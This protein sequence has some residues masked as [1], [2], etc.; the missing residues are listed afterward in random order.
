MTFEGYSFSLIRTD[1]YW[2]IQ[3]DIGVYRNDIEGTL[4]I[5]EG[6]G[7]FTDSDR[8]RGVLES[9]VNGKEGGLEYPQSRTHCDPVGIGFVRIVHQRDSTA[10]NFAMNIQVNKYYEYLM[11]KQRR[12]SLNEVYKPIKMVA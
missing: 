1:G 7:G 8:Y 2:R 5:S 12:T 10:N 11:V 9:I 6:I 4:R 3:R